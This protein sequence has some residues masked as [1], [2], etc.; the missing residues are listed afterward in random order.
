MELIMAIKDPNEALFEE[1]R[2]III[3]Q[4]KMLTKL[5]SRIFLFK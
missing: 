4:R 5:G 2:N 1:V 3:R